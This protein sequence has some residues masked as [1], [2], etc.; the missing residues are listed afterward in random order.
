ME[1]RVTIYELRIWGC[2]FFAR[3]YY[4]GVMRKNKRLFLYAGKKYELRSEIESGRA[5]RWEGWRTR[6][7]CDSVVKSKKGLTVAGVW[8]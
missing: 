4:D 3:L 6:F 5:R 2:E 8:I 1:L 7:A